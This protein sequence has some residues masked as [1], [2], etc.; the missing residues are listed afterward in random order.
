[1][2]NTN[3]LSAEEVKEIS[4]V[5]AEETNED[6]ELVQS[7]PSNGG[8]NVEEELPTP[9]IMEG[10][11]TVNPVTGAY[12]L[13][14]RSEEEKALDEEMAKMLDVQ[15]EN[16]YDIPDSI[17][18]IPYNEELIKKNINEHGISDVEVVS[19]LLPVIEKYRK[20]EKA[21]YYSLL[22]EKIKEMINQQCMITGVPMQDLKAARKMFSEEFLRAIIADAGF[23]KVVIDM[24]KEMQ[25]AYDLKPL[26]SMLMETQK[27]Q[28]E[29]NIDK[30][31]EFFENSEVKPELEDKK[32][33][34]IA[35]LKA[36]KEAYRQSYTLDNFVQAIIDHKIKVKKFDI[37]KYQRHIKEFNFKYEGDTPF[38]IRDIRDCIPVLQRRFSRYPEEYIIRFIVSFIKFTM[39]MS[40]K[41]PIDHTFMSYVISNIISLDEVATTPGESAFIDTLTYHIDRAIRFAN[42]EGDLMSA[43]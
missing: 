21:D 19:E 41:D 35:N 24:Q 31:I 14:E 39:N 40:A 10:F 25:K 11:A 16:L 9:E 1:M 43:K 30:R 4:E 29:D 15:V 3:V 7:L 42:G 33:E 32:A 2:E 27:T 26:M 23:D 28:F 12:R 34:Q 13:D 22:P 18:D 20:Q 6:I 38:I 36:V 17:F 37:E 5:L 8:D